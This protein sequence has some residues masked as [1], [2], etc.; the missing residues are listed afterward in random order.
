M[1]VP[2]G[3]ASH[4]QRSRIGPGRG[5]AVARRVTPELLQPGAPRLALGGPRAAQAPGGRGGTRLFELG[6]KNYAVAATPDLRRRAFTAIKV[7]VA[8]ARPEPAGTAGARV[9]VTSRSVT[10]GSGRA[11]PI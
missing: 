4:W 3:G 7:A 2:A 5:L 6:Y 10:V 8:R 11:G 9:R 1:P